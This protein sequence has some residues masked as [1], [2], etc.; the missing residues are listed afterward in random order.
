M[1]KFISIFELIV[2]K[3]HLKL[4]FLAHFEPYT[5]GVGNF[6]VRGPFY[7]FFRPSGHSF[8]K[9]RA[10]ISSITWTTVDMCWKSYTVG[11]TKGL[12]G[13]HFAHPCYTYNKC[14]TLLLWTM[15]T[16][17]VGNLFDLF[18]AWAEIS[19]LPSILDYHF[20]FHKRKTPRWFWEKEKLIIFF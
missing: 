9:I 16:F 17:P 19:I 11:R 5:P 14:R 6:F 8:K 3:H 20:F 18:S 2:R 7:N 12:G 13:P 1:T 10:E 15:V 4:S